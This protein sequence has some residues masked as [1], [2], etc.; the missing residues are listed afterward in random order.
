MLTVVSLMAANSRPTHAAICAYLAAQ[1]GIELVFVEGGSWQE[2][3]ALLDGGAAQAGFICGL[4]YTRASGRLTPLAAPVMAAPRYGGLPIYFSDV[5][6]RADS[7]FRSFADLR[8][9][10]W[11]FNEPGSLSGQVMVLAHLAALGAPAGYFASARES[12]AHLESLRLVYDGEVDGA[13]VD[14]IVL[15]LATCEQPALAA[16]LRVVASLGPYPAPPL[17]IAAELPG[18]LRDRL[19]RALTVM[20]ADPAGRAILAAGLIDRFV[21]VDDA[22]YNPV[23]EAARAAEGIRLSYEEMY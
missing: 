17:V 16:R 14:S 7:P 18:P 2:H 6:V 3:A 22:D 13:A 10:R 11:A 21:A 9:A 12:G 20:H 8:G 23:R 5:V 1:A 19:A 15:E 4:P